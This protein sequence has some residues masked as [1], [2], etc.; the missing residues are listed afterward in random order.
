[1][2]QELSGSRYHPAAANAP[3]S[4]LIV[5]PVTQD[6]KSD[7]KNN[8]DPAASDGFPKRPYGFHLSI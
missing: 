3:P 2:V 8:A 4:R 6:D 1:M 5:A 7:A